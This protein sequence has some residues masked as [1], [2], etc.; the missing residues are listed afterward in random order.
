MSRI[1]KIFFLLVGLLFFAWAISAVDIGTV[2]DLLGK[3]GIGFLL[4]LLIYWAVTILDTIGWK[5]NFKPE[6]AL[7]F[8]LWQLWKIRQIGE[9]YNT[10]TPLGTLGGEPVKAQ[11]LKDHHK[12]SLKQGL[13][14]QVVG[15][16]TFLTALIIFFIPGTFLILQSDSVSNEFKAV[17]VVGMAVFTTLIFLFF[18]F[19]FTGKLSFLSGLF[20]KTSYGNKVLPFLQKLESLDKLMS[21]YYRE[22]SGLAFKSISCAFIGWVVGL[23]ELYVTLYLLGYDP[24]FA[25]L[26][27]IEALSQL[28]RVGSFFIPLSIGAQEGGLVLIFTGMG[29]PATLGLTVSFVRRIKELTWVGLGLTMSWV[30]AFK[31][32]EI[33]PETFEG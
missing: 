16:T 8:N 18:M 29:L 2:F 22:H 6:Q 3:L 19:Q 1:V 7:Q 30:L 9:A 12:L 28:V 10:I 24:S 11:L 23:G 32:G 20:S 5:L 25:E 17:S 15:R 27:M 26:W 31:P 13:A 14:S 4:V 21:E 33:Q